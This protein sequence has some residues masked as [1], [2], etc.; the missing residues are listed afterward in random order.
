MKMYSGAGNATVIPNPD[1]NE[2]ALTSVAFDTNGSAFLVGIQD[3]DPLIYKLSADGSTLSTITA[4]WPHNHG[5]FNSVSTYYSFTSQQT[6]DINRL[7]M[8]YEQELEE[9]RAKLSSAGL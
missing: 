3:I 7:R 6:Y 9:A 1:G 5:Y 8:I 2:G 4:I